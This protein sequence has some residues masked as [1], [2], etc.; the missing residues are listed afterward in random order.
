MLAFIHIFVLGMVMEKVIVKVKQLKKCY[1]HNKNVLNIDSLIIKEKEKVAVLGN[2]GAGKTTFLKI[3]NNM[4][5]PSSGIVE[6][7]NKNINS[8]PLKQWISYLPQ[9]LVFPKYL[10][11]KE[12]I[13]LIESHFPK[14]DLVIK[15]I[16]ELELEKKCDSY[17]SKLSGGESRKLALICCLINKPK[18]LILDEPTANVDIEG[19]TKIKQLIQ[20]FL[21][22]NPK[23]SLLF[24]SHEVSEIEGLANRAIVLKNG[25]IIS[26]DSIDMIK[27]QFGVKKIFYKS[28]LPLPSQIKSRKHLYDAKKNQHTIWTN[29][30]DKTLKLLLQKDHTLSEIRIED[31]KLDDIF[32]NLW[33]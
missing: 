11:V 33:S 19:K 16:K 23:T 30:S 17:A 26:D 28:E 21:T 6:I 15:Y 20:D 1:N 12:V 7:F 22:S 18:L 27:K 25:K 3:L 8:K 9:N 10:K 2:N 13:Q 32:L 31:P 24:S 5:L 4:A 14:N 29:D